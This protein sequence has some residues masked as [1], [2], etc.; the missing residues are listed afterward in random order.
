M[1]P[2]NDFDL[3]RS[4]YPFSLE[5]KCQF[6]QS[7]NLPLKVLLQLKPSEPSAPRPRPKRR[8]RPEK[9]CLVT[10]RDEAG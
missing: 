6:L 8:K 1:S 7:I 4:D 10:L 9:D 3:L 5:L 2:D